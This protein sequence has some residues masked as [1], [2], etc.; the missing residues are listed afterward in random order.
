MEEFGFSCC[1][2]NQGIIENKTDPVDIKIIL[3]E[4][5]LK[6][7]GCEQI[8]Y[9][10]FNCFK[11]KL[12]QYFKGYF[13]KDN[14]DEII[15]NTKC[16]IQKIIELENVNQLRVLYYG[17]KRGFID[18]QAIIDYC[19]TLVEQTDSKD[20]FV[21]D[22]AALTD[23]DEIYKIPE[24][25]AENIDNPSEIVIDKNQYYSK[26]W[27]YLTLAAQMCAEKIIK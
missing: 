26:I 2:C 5:V 15:K 12:H 16:L 14:E 22:I 3:N 24:R 11:E 23:K 1:F 27:E 19:Y 21:L 8:F 9:A 20:P 10:H 4:D 13:V 6:K 17:L 25:I 18:A 7:T